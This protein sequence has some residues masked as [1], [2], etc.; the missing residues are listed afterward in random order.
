MQKEEY[1]LLQEQN[2]EWTICRNKD[3]SLLVKV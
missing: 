1:K 3:S 2:Q